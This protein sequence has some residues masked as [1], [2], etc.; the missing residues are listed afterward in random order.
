MQQ[1]EGEPVH[2]LYGPE[3]AVHLLHQQLSYCERDISNHLQVLCAA[4]ITSADKKLSF[5]QCWF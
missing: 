1:T 3:L 4:E 5:K 2:Q